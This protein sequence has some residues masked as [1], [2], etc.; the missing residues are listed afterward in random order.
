MRIAS[1]LPSLWQHPAVVS[2]THAGTEDVLF[3]VAPT[4]VVSA[5]ALAGLCQPRTHTPPKQSGSL[6]ESH[7]GTKTLQPHPTRIERP[8]CCWDGVQSHLRWFHFHHLIILY[9][10]LNNFSCDGQMASGGRPRPLLLLCLR[11]ACF[12]DVWGK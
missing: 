12:S 3:S 10:C 5:L 11:I 4:E 7:P 6:M 9:H 8:R 1:F 2:A